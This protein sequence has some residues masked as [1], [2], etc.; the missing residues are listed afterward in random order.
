MTPDFIT[1][2]GIDDRTDLTRADELAARYPIEWG[3]LFSASNRDARYPSDQCINEVLRIRGKMSAHLCGRYAR[4]AA[5]GKHIIM[6]THDLGCFDRFQVNGN[7]LAL[8]GVL[9]VANRFDSS[10]IVQWRRPDFDPES[11]VALLFDRSAGEGLLPDMVPTLLPS[12]RVGYAGGISPDTV[13]MYLSKILGRGPYWIDMETGVRSD[14]WF[15]L[16][17]VEQVCRLVYPTL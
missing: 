10:P 11:P 12:T 16:N 3:I 2:T 14:G 4:A 8:E 1:F 7:L 9:A 5:E 17:K 15:D 6:P 13:G